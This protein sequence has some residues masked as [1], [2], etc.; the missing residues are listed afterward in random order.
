MTDV[1]RADAGLPD[2]EVVLE[3]DAE[4]RRIRTDKLTAGCGGVLNASLGQSLQ[5]RIG[6]N[7]GPVTAGVIGK[8]KFIY[9][10]WGDTVNIASRMESHGQAGF[11]QV[12]AAVREQ[13][14]DGWR[15]ESR[16]EIEVKGKGAMQT[17]FLLGRA[18]AADV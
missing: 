4:A 5:L 2:V 15:F 9:D 6:V 17:Y 18:E 14:G 13:L 1:T 11:I 3:P 16:G 8:R 10:L 12:S 7:C